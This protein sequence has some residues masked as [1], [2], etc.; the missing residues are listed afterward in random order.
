MEDAMIW[1]DERRPLTI[2]EAHP[3]H[4]RLVPADRRFRSVGVGD[5]GMHLY[6]RAYTPECPRCRAC[7]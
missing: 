2:V 1:R 5:P 6:R 7:E 4:E 3:Y